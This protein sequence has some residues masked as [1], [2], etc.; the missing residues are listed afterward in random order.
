MNEPFKVDF[1]GK[2]EEILSRPVPK[3][4]YAE[5][6]QIASAAFTAQENLARKF[7]FKRQIENV[8]QIYIAKVFAFSE[9]ERRVQWKMALVAFAAFVQMVRSPNICFDAAAFVHRII[10]QEIASVA[11]IDRTFNII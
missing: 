9:L 3:E 4:V 5:K 11:F 8:A 7:W 6:R 1:D 10:N 2:R